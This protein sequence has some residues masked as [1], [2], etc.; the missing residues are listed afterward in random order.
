MWRAHLECA[1]MY[2]GPFPAW[3][4]L[5]ESVASSSVS[6]ATYVAV[7]SPANYAW[8]GVKDCTEAMAT[9][10]L[11]DQAFLDTCVEAL[12]TYTSAPGGSFEVKRTR[13]NGVHCLGFAS[14]HRD[15]SLGG[16]YESELKL[17]PQ[18]NVCYVADSGETVSFAAVQCRLC[19]LAA[20]F[21]HVLGV[22]KG[23]RVSICLRNCPEWCISFVAA[24]ATGAIAVPLNSWWQPQ[25]LAYGL[26]DSGSKVMVCDTERLQRTNLR[27][28]TAVLV[29]GDESRHQSRVE[30][31]ASLVRTGGPSAELWPKPKPPVTIDED[32]VIMYTSGTTGNPKGVVQTHRNIL[33]QLMVGRVQTAARAFAVEKLVGPMPAP[34]GCAIC[35]VPLFH[36]TASHHIFLAGLLNGHKI[37][38]MRKWDPTAA[39]RLVQQHKVNY[40]IGVPTMVQDLLEHPEFDLYDTSVSSSPTQTYADSLVVL[41]RFPPPQHPH[42]S[43]VRPDEPRSLLFALQSLSVQI[44]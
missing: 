42:L 44:R 7:H 25:E 1:P 15:S 32:A 30:N 26:Q 4:A 19:A 41:C 36:V 11:R 2:R 5:W 3:M 10:S 40:W 39:L 27:N 18:Q 17:Q 29:H 9:I 38:F 13:I 8:R 34:Q 21:S 31:Y 35:T 22:A 20:G 24:V 12:R 6:C 14:L 43:P 16:L 33:T 28:V 37:L 23:D